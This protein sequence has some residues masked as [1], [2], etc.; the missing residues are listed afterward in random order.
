M[1]EIRNPF[2]PGAGTPPPDLTGRMDLVERAEILLRRIK[3]ARSGKSLIFTGLRGVGKTVLLN[4]IKRISRKLDYHRMFIEAHEDKP[5][6]ALLAPELR[7][8]LY[9]LDRIEGS[10]QKVR[11]GLV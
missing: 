10:K 11:R 5:L 8:L 1:D 2:T 6:A 9:S 7:S 3:V 4:E